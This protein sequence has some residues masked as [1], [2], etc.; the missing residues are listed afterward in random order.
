[1]YL[2][3]LGGGIF[4]RHLLAHLICLSSNSDVSLFIFFFRWPDHWRKQGIGI[5]SSNELMLVHVFNFSS[6]L[7]MKLDAPSLV[8]ICLE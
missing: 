8:H 7:F 1:M 4:C 3:F 6:A 5:T 2:C